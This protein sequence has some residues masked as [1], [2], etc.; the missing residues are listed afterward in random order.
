[1]TLCVLLS[2]NALL[3]PS[4]FRCSVL[5]PGWTEQRAE[6]WIT[7]EKAQRRHK[8]N[9]CH[10]NPCL[11]IIIQSPKS[12]RFRNELDVCQSALT[13]LIFKTNTDSKRAPKPDKVH[14]PRNYPVW[15]CIKSTTKAWILVLLSI[16]MADATIED[17]VNLKTRNRLITEILRQN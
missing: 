7:G 1:M 2:L 10:C 17:G 16:E 8:E 9:L 11:E 13:R 15:W 4:L 12:G 5:C 6:V 14:P 3:E